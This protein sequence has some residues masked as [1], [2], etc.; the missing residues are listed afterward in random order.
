MLQI[1]KETVSQK[2]IYSRW[3][4]PEFLE[5]KGSPLAEMVYTQTTSKIGFGQRESFRNSSILSGLILGI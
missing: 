5:E 4:R 2:K 1:N 3:Y